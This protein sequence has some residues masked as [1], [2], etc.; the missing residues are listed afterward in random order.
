[1]K[2]SKKSSDKRTF[3][4]VAVTSGQDETACFVS[5]EKG[6]DY[7]CVFST[8]TGSFTT[9]R[10]TQNATLC[11]TVMVEQGSTCITLN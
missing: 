4:Q 6:E 3:T 1:M 8:V 5:G 10:N 9:A 2:G 7:Q 11:D